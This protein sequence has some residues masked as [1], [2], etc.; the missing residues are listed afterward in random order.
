MLQKNQRNYNKSEL[1]TKDL[2][3]YI[4]HGLL[5]SNGDRWKQNRKLIQPAFY[6]KQLAEVIGTMAAAVRD[7]LSVVQTGS[8]TDVFPVMNE[9]AFQ[10]VAQ[11]L[12][13]L[14]DTIHTYSDYMSTT[15]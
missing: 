4:G 12:F 5:T 9:L 1:Q 11:S 7:H 2:A 14:D 15:F 13:N 3:K 10:V 8:F 6:K